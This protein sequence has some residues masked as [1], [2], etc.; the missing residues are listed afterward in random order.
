MD[1]AYNI[2]T[3]HDTPDHSSS[4]MRDNIYL[5]QFKPSVYPLSAP[6][7]DAAKIFDQAQFYRIFVC[8]LTFSSLG[9]LIFGS[10]A[11]LPLMRR[12]ERE[13]RRWYYG[14]ILYHRR[15]SV[16]SNHESCVHFFILHADGE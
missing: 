7:P 6:S 13:V 11:L 5:A 16:I 15:P 10:L 2:M 14:A 4:T 12:F 9:E 8:N 1:I 3:D